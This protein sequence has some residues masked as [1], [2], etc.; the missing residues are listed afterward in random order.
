MRWKRTCWIIGVV[1]LGAGAATAQTT[2]YLQ[3]ASFVPPEKSALAVSVAGGKLDEVQPARW[4]D[5]VDWLFARSSGEQRNLENVKPAAGESAISI[6][7]TRPGVTMIGL[8]LPPQIEV[9]SA[10][11]WS[12]FL[13]TRVAQ[14]QMQPALPAVARGDPARVEHVRSAK[15][16][17]RVSGHSA[18]GH[19]AVAQSKSGQAVEIRALADPT[20]VP[21]GSDLPVR[22]Y[23]DGEKRT[24]VRVLASSVTG[25]T[26]QGQVTDATGACH[27][28]IT[29]EGEW[30]VEV[31][32][33]TAAKDKSTAYW[34]L[35]TATL[36]FFVS[37]VQ[38]DTP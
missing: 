22:V 28:R 5:E 33:L 30:R 19:S 3:P 35:H 24:G 32:D 10:K 2:L 9:V 11:D 16:L 17:V 15:T 34:V 13:L 7:L 25:G 31:H 4:P 37:P 27:F 29:H 38:G 36:T 12:P 21:V 8:D 20:R 14:D 26:R 1:G 6:E 18:A 23:V